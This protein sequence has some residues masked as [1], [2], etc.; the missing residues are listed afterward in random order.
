MINFNV[1]IHHEATPDP[2]TFHLFLFM[3]KKTYCNYKFIII[4]TKNV[5]IFYHDCDY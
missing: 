1:K 5:F 3:F 4:V 2:Y